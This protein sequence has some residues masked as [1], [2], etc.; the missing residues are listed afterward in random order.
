MSRDSGWAVRAGTLMAALFTSFSCLAS[1]AETIVTPSLMLV[2]NSRCEEG[3]VGCED[4]TLTMVVRQTGETVLGV[5]R[6]LHV[7]LADGSPG[8]FS[9][10]QFLMGGGDKDAKTH[11]TLDPSNMV[12][13]AVNG[14]IVLSEQG[15]PY[16]D[17]GVVPRSKPVEVP[18]AVSYRSGLLA[19]GL[20][21][22]FKNISGS[23]IAVTAEIVRPSTGRR[24]AFELVIN[25]GG[26]R[27]IGELEGW[28]FVSGDI[29]TVSQGGSGPKSVRIP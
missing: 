9:G 1:W 24:Q 2:I 4:M 7:R 28:A 8:A 16:S 12:R 22:T 15:E 14:T 25:G 17:G 27:E 19:N 10:Y 29:V 11:V 5:G 26:I 3:V 6:A 18:V 20:V 21:A 13:L 23:A